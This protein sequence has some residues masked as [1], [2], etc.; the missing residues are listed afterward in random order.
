MFLVLPGPLIG[1]AVIWLVNRPEIPFLGWLYGHSIFAPWLALL[2]RSLPLATLVMWMSFRT[3]PQEII[4]AAALDGAGS[5]A[6][7]HRILIPMRL[8]ALAL[9]WLV[10]FTIALADLAASILV[11]PP[12]LTTLSVRIFGLLHYGV[13]DRVAGI[14]LA[15]V[16]LLAALVGLAVWLASKGSTPGR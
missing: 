3:I 12:G 14:C 15:L 7:L 4:D 8:P 9:A 16:T 1:L 6:R 5:L 2:I 10:V 13:E 11:I